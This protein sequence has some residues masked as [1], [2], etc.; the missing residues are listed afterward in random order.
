MAV[1]VQVDGELRELKTQLV[2]ELEREG[3]ITAKHQFLGMDKISCELTLKA[4]Q[5]RNDN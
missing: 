5:V 2:E 1:T 4:I 3:A